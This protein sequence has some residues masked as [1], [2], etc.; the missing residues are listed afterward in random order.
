MIFHCPNCNTRYDQDNLSINSKVRCASCG[1]KFFINDAQHEHSIPNS[2]I[3]PPAPAPSSPPAT[4]KKR[5]AS[6]KFLILTAV[7]LIALIIGYFFLS[8]YIQ[9]ATASPKAPQK[10]LRPQP[11]MVTMPTISPAHHAPIPLSRGGADTPLNNVFQV[12]NPQVKTDSQGR[13]W[14][15]LSGHWK[16]IKPFSL[17]KT[18]L[19][20]TFI[21]QGAANR[22]HG[23][24]ARGTRNYDNFSALQFKGNTLRISG[25]NSKGYAFGA[26]IKNHASI[27]PNQPLLMRMTPAGAKCKVQINAAPPILIPSNISTNFFGAAYAKRPHFNGKI[28]ELRTYKPLNPELT[29]YV[30]AELAEFWGINKNASGFKK[31]YRKAPASLNQ[32]VHQSSSNELTLALTPYFRDAK[33]FSLYLGRNNAD[34]ESSISELTPDRGITVRSNAVWHIGIPAQA[35][36]KLYFKFNP[37][38]TNKLAKYLGKHGFFALL[39]RASENAPFREIVNSKAAPDG[40]VSFGPFRPRSGFYTL[41]VIQGVPT[42]S[43]ELQILVN[44]KPTD[45]PLTFTPGEQL[46]ITCKSKQPFDITLKESNN[47]IIWYQGP[48]DQMNLNSWLIRSGATKLTANIASKPGFVAKKINFTIRVNNT[49]FALYPG[50]TAQLLNLNVNRKIAANGAFPAPADVKPQHRSVGTSL[51]ADPIY[52]SYPAYRTAESV[53]KANHAPGK[54]GFTLPDYWQKVCV[55][56]SF[57]RNRAHAYPWQLTTDY[58]FGDLTNNRRVAIYIKGLLMIE[59]PGTYTFQVQANDSLKMSIADK[60]TTLNIDVAK[61]AK[62]KWP[63]RTATIELD[64]KPGLVPYTM[65]LN[66]QSKSPAN[67]HLLWKTPDSDKFVTLNGSHFLHKVD[68]K[69]EQAYQKFTK[70]TPWR[71]ITPLSPSKPTTPARAFLQKPDFATRAANFPSFSTTGKQLLNTWKYDRELA[72]SPEV[73]NALLKLIIERTNVQRKDKKVGKFRKQIVPGKW[74][75]C[76]GYYLTYDISLQPFLEA[77]MRHPQLQKTALEARNAINAYA[78]RVYSRSFFSENHAGTNDGYN[79]FHNFIVNVWRAARV[80]DDPYA[81]DAARSL[82]DNHFR[83]GPGVKSGLQSDNIFEFHSANGRHVSQGGY[84]DNWLSRTLNTINYA[85]PWGNTREQYRR[86]AE[87]VL[88][89]EWFYYKGARSY[90]FAGR[91]RTGIGRFGLKLINKLYS[92]PRNA[93]D[94][95]TW[96]K[97]DKVKARFAKKQPLV[98]NHFFARHLL[99][100]HRRKDFFLEV[101]MAAPGVGGVETFAGAMPG[102]LSFG[103]GVTTILKHGNEYKAINAVNIPQALWKFRALPGTTQLNYEWPRLDRYRGWAGTRAGGVSDGE[104][105][106]CAFEFT[107]HKRNA[108][109]ADKMFTFLED[110]M[111]VL[112]SGISGSRKASRPYY[113]YRSNINQC[114]RK[115]DIKITSANGK[116]IV[117]AANEITKTIKLPM[118]QSYWITH[119][120]IGYLVVPT[121]TELGTTSNAIANLVIESEVRT[122]VNRLQPDIWKNKKNAA[123]KK[124]CEALVNRKNPRQANVLTIWIDHGAHPKDA[125]CCYMVCMRPEK[126][127]VKQWLKKPPFTILSNDKNLQAIRDDRKNILHAFFY[128]PKLASLKDEKGQTILAVEEPASVMIRPL[129]NGKTRY[130][131]QDPFAAICWKKNNKA[132]VIHLTHHK[133][134]S[135]KKINIQLPGAYDPDDRYK[136]APITIEQ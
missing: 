26:N 97:L 43:P 8:Q 17:S 92:L 136:A 119:R 135:A 104:F 106:H 125:T 50:L 89:Y 80:I 60:E 132:N 68:A 55:N 66:H 15:H 100:I 58:P 22:Y 34:N 3:T 87:Y 24:F 21:P 5:R 11:K 133:N 48:S 23:L 18:Q 127:P 118:N 57:S 71:T 95:A 52:K 113:S 103:D 72:G 130:T 88:A 91:A 31:G 2:P 30:S 56:P 47:G 107:S 51:S 99:H 108:T 134:G 62:A 79:D 35:P 112:G 131:V 44:G 73:A 59:Q 81:F 117:I 13:H 37:D 19:F 20:L 78:N 77:C 93:L 70:N 101:K 94:E 16:L 121:H 6:A 67:V 76:N 111:V 122:P 86:L 33:K 75:V 40:T 110:G 98:G 124:Q 39:Y 85:T 54:A 1:N 128:H 90:S 46:H 38:L 126:A 32:D 36:N 123:Y 4:P 10:K 42:K 27:R 64:L 82:Y 74:S 14:K 102:N 65:M 7:S 129:A 53:I 83:Y 29:A 25:E 63:M 69:V 61:D 105:G 49:N 84:G 120:G 12:N 109:K 28:G 9:S 114:E 96:E 115:G 41:G 45:T 116:T